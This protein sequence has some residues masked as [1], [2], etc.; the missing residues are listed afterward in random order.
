MQNIKSE[1]NIN[2]LFMP[3][4]EQFQ[5]FVNNHRKYNPV[6]EEDEEMKSSYIIVAPSGRLVD[7]SNGTYKYGEALTKY[8]FRDGYRILL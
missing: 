3:T 2:T 4:K 6:V 5:Y 7:K 1:K 8:S